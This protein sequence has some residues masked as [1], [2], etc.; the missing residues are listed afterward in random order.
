VILVILAS[1]HFKWPGAI[2]PGGVVL[3][4]ILFNT[5]VDTYISYSLNR[6]LDTGIGVAVALIINLLL[7]RDRVNSVLYKL[8]LRKEE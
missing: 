2:Q 4:I 3:C 1:L 6:M 8:K 7:P 5:P